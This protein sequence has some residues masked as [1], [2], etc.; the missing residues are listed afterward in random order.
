MAKVERCALE[1][2]LPGHARGV[3]IQVEGEGKVCVH[4]E[5]FQRQT[6]CRFIG[7]IAI[8]GDV[9]DFDACSWKRCDIEPFRG[10]EAI[11][12]ELLVRLRAAGRNGDPDFGI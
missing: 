10:G 3:A 8:V 6:R 12:V 1:H 4:G 2:R 11:G 5:L 7:A 9:E